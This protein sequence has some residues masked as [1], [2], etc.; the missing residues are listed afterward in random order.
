MCSRGFF[1]SVLRE[2]EEIRS[3]LDEERP[4]LLNMEDMLLQYLWW[5]GEILVVREM[6]QL[7][8]WDVNWLFAHMLPRFF[9][10]PDQAGDPTLQDLV[11]RD[12]I[13][14]SGF[15]QIFFFF[16][17]TLL[18]FFLFAG[19]CQRMCCGKHWKRGSPGKNS[20]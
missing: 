10:R 6:P 14:G 4:H 18:I 20:C 12:A 1:L 13:Q 8:V 17:S 7:V 2:N 19:S 9:E 15:H 16:H 5:L 3:V 11:C